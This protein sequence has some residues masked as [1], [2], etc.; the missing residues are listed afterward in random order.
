[1]FAKQ[2]KLCKIENTK[3]IDMRPVLNSD[4][5]E[6]LREPDRILERW[7]EHYSTLLNRGTPNVT[8]ATKLT[9]E[10]LAAPITMDEVK[11]AIKQMK[12]GKAAGIDLIQAEIYKYGGETVIDWMWRVA[13]AAWREEEVPEDRRKMIIIPVHKGNS[14]EECTNSRGI[15]LLSV[16]GKNIHQDYS[17]PTE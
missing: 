9:Q 16:A 14:R 17:Q 6:L 5:S 15:S 13:S 8:P 2:R 3:L 12:N 4:G 11:K 7:A 1:M 10:E